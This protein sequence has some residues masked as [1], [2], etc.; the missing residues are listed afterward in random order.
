MLYQSKLDITTLQERSRYIEFKVDD[1]ISRFDCITINFCAENFCYIFPLI[2]YCFI[3]IPKIWF[4]KLPHKGRKQDSKIYKEVFRNLIFSSGTWYPT[5]SKIS[6]WTICCGDNPGLSNRPAQHSVVMPNEVGY[7][8]QLISFRC[9]PTFSVN[10]LTLRTNTAK[11]VFVDKN[12]KVIENYY[13]VGIV[14]QIVELSFLYDIKVS[15]H[16]QVQRQCPKLFVGHPK[17]NNK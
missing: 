17:I 4:R 2:V 1:V 10:K 6:S 15:R 5:S 13:V 7:S 14:G 16:S 8:L 11:N 12:W 3:S 9:F